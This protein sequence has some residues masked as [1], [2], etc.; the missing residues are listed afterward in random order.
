MAPL[1]CAGFAASVYALKE[2][3]PCLRRETA[4]IRVVPVAGKPQHDLGGR[5][6]PALLDGPVGGGVA[7]RGSPEMEKGPVRNTGPV[8]VRR[9]QKGSGGAFPRRTPCPWQGRGW[10]EGGNVGQGAVRRRT[11]C[12]LQGWSAGRSR[13]RSVGGCELRCRVRTCKPRTQ[14][15]EPRKNV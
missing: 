8:G 7:H 1:N 4:K 6:Q 10:Q 12:R 11:P 3:R 15:W 5:L 13:C 14:R 9:D 2:R